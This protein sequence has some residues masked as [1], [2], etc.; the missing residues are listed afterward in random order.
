MVF[1]TTGLVNASKQLDLALDAFARLRQIVP[2]VYYL[3]VGGSHTDVN[4][5]KL[6]RQRNL[7]ES[8]HWT[9]RVGSLEEF[10]GWTAAADV[11]INL[12]HPT[13]GEAS[14]AA[15]RGLA[16]GK[17]L[18]VYDEGW[19]A[20]LPSELCLQIAPLDP[21]AL[22]EAMLFSVHN[23]KERLRMG[24]AAVAFAESRLDPHRVARQYHRFIEEVIKG[25]WPTSLGNA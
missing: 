10:V 6:I 19:Y 22:F 9:D 25:I 1:A 14:N 4:L 3:I 17:P 15:V 20:E 18:I 8:V 2:D 23:P 16:A 11:V 12:R 24:R 5:P 21:D 13:L 7:Q